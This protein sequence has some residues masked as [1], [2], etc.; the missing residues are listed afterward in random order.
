MS[1]H[2][3]LKPF[4]FNLSD[5]NFI[6]DQINF[7]PL[8]DALGNVIVAWDG[9]GAIYDS[10]NLASRTMLWNGT[11]TMLSQGQRFTQ[12]PQPMQVCGSIVT[13]SVPSARVIAPV[14]QPTRHTGSLH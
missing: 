5:L 9:T 12:F 7:R 4:N 8:F 3:K 14:G 10:N 1:T 11:S 13:S 2:F 6:R